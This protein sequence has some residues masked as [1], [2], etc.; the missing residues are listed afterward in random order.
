MEEWR[1]AGSME[2]ERR[3]EKE[4][5]EKVGVGKKRSSWRSLGDDRDSGGG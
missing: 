4:G 3:R 5:G 1:L 2:G